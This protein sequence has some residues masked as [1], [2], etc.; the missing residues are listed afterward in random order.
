MAK[1][2]KADEAVVHPW[3]YAAG[4]ND[5]ST[6]LNKFGVRYQDSSLGRWTTQDPLRQVLSTC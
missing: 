1:I 4:Y 2:E 3:Q 6:G 5:E